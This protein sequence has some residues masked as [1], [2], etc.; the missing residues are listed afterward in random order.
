MIL[1]VNKKFQSIKKS[2]SGKGRMNTFSCIVKLR[3]CAQFL[4]KVSL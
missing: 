4:K 2:A 1:D 3:T